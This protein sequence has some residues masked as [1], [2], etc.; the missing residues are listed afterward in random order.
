[1]SIIKFD[2]ENLPWI[3]QVEPSST[4]YQNI[5]F[6]EIMDAIE[7]T[8]AD[9][10][11]WLEA[12]GALYEALN[13]VK[14]VNTTDVL[15][16]KADGNKIEAVYGFVIRLID[17]VACLQF[18]S[19]DSGNA[20]PI[21]QNGKRL[22]I[23]SLTG[24][25]VAI[26]VKDQN[27]D[28]KYHALSW[29]PCLFTDSGDFVYEFP[30]MLKTESSPDGKKI[31]APV[32][33]IFLEKLAKKN[34][35]AEWLSEPPKGGDGTYQVYGNMMRWFEG[36]VTHK[37][38]KMSS[39]TYSVV[40]MSV[41]HG[42]K[43]ADGKAFTIVTLQLSD[44]EWV[45]ANSQAKA[46]VDS[47]DPSQIVF[48]CQWVLDVYAKD[49]S[50]SYLVFDAPAKP[51]TSIPSSLSKFKGLGAAKPVKALPEPTKAADASD[52]PW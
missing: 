25:M 17:G 4:Q 33:D 31:Y 2:I 5:G 40:G 16:I 14:E 15:T 48:P 7:R 11:Q 30:I 39:G 47:N 38:Y 10:S 13:A 42:T 18:G 28:T 1:M 12:F 45:E 49:K 46:W 50:S 51:L 34:N 21:E 20:Y 23:G 19:L 9:L 37:P 29:K 36:K 52:L 22:T 24:D 3:F 27:G 41:K 43:K 6:T 8:P 44:G 32:D 35:L 26:P